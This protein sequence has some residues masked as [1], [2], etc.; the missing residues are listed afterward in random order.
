MPGDENA[1]GWGPDPHPHVHFRCDGC[2]GFFFNKYYPVMPEGY[3]ATAHSASMKLSAPD[4]SN[5]M[6]AVPTG[7]VPSTKFFIIMETVRAGVVDLYLQAPEYMP[8]QFEF[9]LPPPARALAAT[10]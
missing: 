9:K 10:L 4:A 6:H 1:V 7:Q 2:G 8:P 3:C 5:L